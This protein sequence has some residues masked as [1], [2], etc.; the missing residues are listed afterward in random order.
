MLRLGGRL[1]WADPWAVPRQ[2]SCKRGVSPAPKRRERSQSLAA[3]W[4]VL[5]LPPAGFVQL[6]PAAPFSGRPGRAQ[7]PPAMLPSG[8]RGSAPFVAAVL[9]VLGAPL[10]KGWGTTR[11]GVGRGDSGWHGM[12]W[13]DVKGTRRVPRDCPP[14]AIVLLSRSPR[15]FAVAPGAGRKGTRRSGSGD[16]TPDPGFSYR[17]R[18]TS[19]LSPS[20]WK[21]KWAFSF[22][23]QWPEL[24]RTDVHWAPPLLPAALANEDCLWYLD[25]NGSWHP[26]FD[27]EF[28]TFCCGTCYHRY[29]CRDLTLLITERQQ[30]HCL[31]FRWAANSHS[32]PSQ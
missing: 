1:W 15:C 29:C 14:Q 18:G 4:A 24:N 3:G 32:T 19:R 13:E 28:I 9:L 11:H 27:C 10:G 6:C 8:A 16:L 7:A 23:K 25:R 22:P 17:E 26:G 20:G 31:A 21:Q 30:K 5:Q 12:G 2:G